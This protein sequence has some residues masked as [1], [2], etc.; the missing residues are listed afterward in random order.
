MTHATERKLRR[1]EK[2]TPHPEPLVKW[3]KTH[4]AFARLGV[5][6]RRVIQIA[7]VAITLIG[8]N[9]ITISCKLLVV[10]EQIMPK[11]MRNAIERRTICRAVLLHVSNMKPSYMSHL[12]RVG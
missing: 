1:K 3:V 8:A 12:R 7:I 9:Q 5:R 11:R 10:R 4:F 2:P 6:T